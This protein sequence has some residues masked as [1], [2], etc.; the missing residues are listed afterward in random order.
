MRCLKC[1]RIVV[2]VV[3][4]LALALYA[5]AMPEPY[6]LMQD[7]FILTFGA[8]GNPL[9]A[10]SQIDSTGRI[11]FWNMEKFAGSF[12]LSTTAGAAAV[13]LGSQWQMDFNQGTFKITSQPAGNG[14]TLWEG[15]V[16]SFLVTGNND[17]SKFSAAPYDRPSYE[18]DPASFDQVCSATFTRTSGVWT[19]QVI[20]MEWGGTYNIT[21]DGNTIPESSWMLGNLQGKLV[22]VPEPSGLLLIGGGL[23]SLAG[24]IKRRR[25]R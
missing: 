13:N 11:V 15:A 4:L 24:V 20:E 14:V 19:D 12:S 5:Q 1:T 21:F 8:P 23:A 22:T 10:G 25:T 9:A 17:G 18:D 7:D 3:S 2:L 6:Y 16:S